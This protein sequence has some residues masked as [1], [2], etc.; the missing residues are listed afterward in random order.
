MLIA[1]KMYEIFIFNIITYHIVIHQMAYNSRRRFI[2]MELLAAD[3]PSDPSDV[4]LESEI[5]EQ[6]IL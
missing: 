1:L 2:Q 4:T 5:T 6:R 3:H